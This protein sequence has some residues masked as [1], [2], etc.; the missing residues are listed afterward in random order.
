MSLYG[1]ALKHVDM[2]RV[3][4]LHEQKLEENDILKRLE[5]ERLEYLKNLCSPE[6]SNW[7]HELQEA[8][9]MSSA[10]MFTATLPATGDVALQT[11]DTGSDDSFGLDDIV[12]L[13][14]YASGVKTV[15][16]TGSEFNGVFGSESFLKFSVPFPQDND[17]TGTPYRT[18]SYFY[19][20]TNIFTANTNTVTFQAIAGNST[21]GTSLGTGTNGGT[22]PWKDVDV[23]WYQYDD[24]DTIIDAGTL[25]VIPKTTHSLTNFEFTLPENLA[26]KRIALSFYNR[27]NTGGGGLTSHSHLRG[28][29]LPSFHPISTINSKEIAYYV[30]H[31]IHWDMLPTSSYYYP[32]SKGY[33]GIALW[34]AL[35]DQYTGTDWSAGGNGYP[36]PVSGTTTYDEL[37]EADYN[38]IADAVL[39]SPLINQRG[40]I[41]T[42][43]GIGNISLKRK[44][45]MNV[46][47]SLDS[48]EA[49]AFIRTDSILSNLS[50][51]ERLKKLKEML[52][53]GDEYV[54]K[55]LG[56]DFP[57]TG[58]TPPGEAGDTPGVELTDITSDAV[59]PGMGMGDQAALPLAIGLA[60]SPM[61]QMAIAAGAVAVASLLGI[62]VQK[63]QEVI[64]QAN[65]MKGG[66]DWGA[67]PGQDTIPQDGGPA[68]GQQGKELTPQQQAEVEA[69]GKEL[70][71]AQRALNDLPADATDAQRDMAQERVDR[72]SKNRTRL[73]RKHREENKNRKESFET[74]GEVLIEKKNLRSV[75]NLLG[76]IP[77][78]YDG[79]PSPLGFP[80]EP[81][82]KT[83]NGYHP[84]LV[85]GKKVAQ[86]Y[87]RLDPISAKSMPP[88]GNPHIDKKVKAAAKKP[89]YS[90]WKEELSDI[91]EIVD[92]VEAPTMGTADILTAN[93]PATGEATLAQYPN[94]TMTDANL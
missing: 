58:A 30:W 71:D 9:T 23:Y 92:I 83:I 34:N 68:I 57:G 43:Y 2:K 41:P 63:A 53:A 87:N 21:E 51:Q 94:M 19:V 54:A 86:R 12:E 84:D 47:V 88:T 28:M 42:T 85:D 36:A 82:P 93:F 55:M 67:A 18:P 50:P 48:P 38:Y 61:G 6:F 1:R 29:S 72:A 77:G 91:V 81:P 66:S 60:A 90:N 14:A 73:R 5:E 45:P 79:K 32:S 33:W 3:K 35:Q 49:A 7:R 70:R 74:K 52:D 15:K 44:T 69:A 37:T 20:T 40:K 75:K 26:G 39:A 65:A 11:I 16:G 24:N 22:Q 13:G 31:A 56:A 17:A 8:P 10:G 76:K 25:G 89:K 27:A 64:Q 80:V 78:Y 46:L 4:K 62:T 59:D